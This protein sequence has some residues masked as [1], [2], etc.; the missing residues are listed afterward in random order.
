MKFLFLLYDIKQP[1]FDEG[2]LYLLREEINKNW[3]SKDYPI[4]YPIIIQRYF[5]QNKL[6]FESQLNKHQ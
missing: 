3:E 5:K 4:S 2:Q 6:K 1:Q